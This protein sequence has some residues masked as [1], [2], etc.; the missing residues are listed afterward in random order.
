MIGNRLRFLSLQ[1]SEQYTNGKRERHQSNKS[2]ACGEEADQQMVVRAVEQ[3][4]GYGIQMVYKLISTE[5]RN[6][7]KDSSNTR[8]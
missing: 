3:G 2:C 1:K 5:P 7:I 6:A 8:N 4:S